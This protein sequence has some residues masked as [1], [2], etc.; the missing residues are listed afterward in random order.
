MLLT[1]VLKRIKLSI[2]GS[3][4]V[5]LL[6]FFLRKQFFSEEREKQNMFHCWGWN[7][8]PHMLGKHRIQSF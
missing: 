8:G 3:E 6:G 1:Q 7:P 2:T 4:E 5:F